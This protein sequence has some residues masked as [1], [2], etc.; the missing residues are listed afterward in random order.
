MLSSVG[1]ENAALKIAPPR[2]ITVRNKKKRATQ[3][4]MDGSHYK[5]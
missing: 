1:A 4:P 5:V 2:Y 3:I